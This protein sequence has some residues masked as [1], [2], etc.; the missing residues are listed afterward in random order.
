MSQDRAGS[1]G[2]SGGEREKVESPFIDAVGGTDQ[3]VYMVITHVELGGTFKTVVGYRE[4]VAKARDF[5]GILCE[6]KQIGDY[7]A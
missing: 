5:R 4:A 2:T 1:A 3:R 7:R 6:L